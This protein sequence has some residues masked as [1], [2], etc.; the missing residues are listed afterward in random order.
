MLERDAMEEPSP[1]EATPDL[2]EFHRLLLQRFPAL[3]AFTEDQWARQKPGVS[4]W[5]STPQGSDRC[6][7]L[8]MR[9]DTPRKVFDEILALGKRFHLVIYDPQNG[10]LRRL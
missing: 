9:L 3:E 5:T 1:F 8:L 4:P 7:G 6:V 10:Q 2:V